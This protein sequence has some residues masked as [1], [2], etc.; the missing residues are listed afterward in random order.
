MSLCIQVLLYVNIHIYI[1]PIED[2]VAKNLE[3]ISKNYQFSTRILMGCI[4]ST[5]RSPGTN[6]KSH[7]QNSSSSK[8]FEK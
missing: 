2:R 3:N 1:Q 7:G 5:M 4:I 6:R 8:K